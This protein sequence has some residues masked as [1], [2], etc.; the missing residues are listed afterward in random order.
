M[1]TVTHMAL[2]T[3]RESFSCHNYKHVVPNGTK[4]TIDGN[5]SLATGI[6]WRIVTMQ[7]VSHVWH[8]I[9]PR[10]LRVMYI[11]FAPCGA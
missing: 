4:A 6:R 5:G 10:E 9:G 11:G 3:E 7:D 1:F 8:K 2:L